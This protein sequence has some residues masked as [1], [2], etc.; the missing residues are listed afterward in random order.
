MTGLLVSVRDARE[1]AAALRGGA[2]VIDIKEPLHGSLGAATPACWRNVVRLVDQRLPVSV[3]LGELADSLLT[4]RL[5]ELPAGICFA[6]LGL[7]GCVR[8]PDWE[9]RWEQAIASLPAAVRPVAVVYADEQRAEAPAAQRIV[10]LAAELG[11][12]AVL[13]DTFDK[14]AGSLL[15]HWTEQRLLGHLDEVAQAGMLTVLAGSLEAEL[16]PRLPLDR[17]DLLAVR[18]A[19][20]RG[21][22]TTAVDPRRVSQLAQ[23]L[24]RLS[25]ADLPCSL[26][27][28]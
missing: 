14:R 17:V 19:V 22:R 2:D 5:A 20:C 25:P 12:Q 21:D 23:Q 26:L 9:A 27:S 13:V 18:G 10:A 8:Q 15:E 4:D 11:C 1:A 28:Q 3:A 7:A 16:L 6:K 24:A